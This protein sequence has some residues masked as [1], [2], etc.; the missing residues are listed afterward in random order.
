MKSH[1]ARDTVTLL[2]TE[3][4][5]FI[6]PEMWPPNSPDLNQ[7]DYSG[8]PSREGLY[9]SRIHD[10]SEGVERT[11]AERMEAAGPLQCGSIIAAAIAQWRSCLSTCIRVNGRHFA[12]KFCSCD[13]LV[14]FIR[15]VDTS[16]R[17]FDRYK[18]V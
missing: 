15:F 16:F 18:H 10:V 12:H 11:S 17:K 1:C 13:F 3:M 8:C 5:E 2:Q 14:S 9:R 6:P 4:S 7:V